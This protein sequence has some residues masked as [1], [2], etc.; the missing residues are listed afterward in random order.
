MIYAFGAYT[1]DTD[2]Y[3]L[4][5]AGMVCPLEPHAVDILT[6]LLQHRDRVVT[7]RELLEQLWPGRFVGE[8]ILA[9]RLMTIR[10]AIGDSGQN[11]HC[12]KTV[13]GRGYR[14]AAEV[15]VHADAAMSTYQ[16]DGQ[17]AMRSSLVDV[18][19][20][21]TYSRDAA[22]RAQPPLFSRPPHFVGR[23]A[24]LARLGAVVEQSTAGHAT[25]RVYRRGTW[26]WKDGAGR[27]VCRAGRGH[28]GR[29][30]RVRPMRG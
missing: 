26:D 6:Y 10:K 24:E 16:R 7:K 23:D 29:L 14:F 20:A 3:E 27:C 11:Q 4:R 30:S 19:C 21:E 28:A 17:S 12:I 15:A 18:A 2:R 8:G 9:Q 25:S 1:L 13:H 5:R 22:S